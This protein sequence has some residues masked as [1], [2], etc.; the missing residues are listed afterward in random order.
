MNKLMANIFNQLP[1]KRVNKTLLLSRNLQMHVPTNKEGWRHFKDT[2]RPV[3]ILAKL[4]EMTIVP[5]NITTEEE[6]EWK[7]KDS[8]YRRINKNK[9][10][11]IVT[12]RTKENKNKGGKHRAR[13]C[14]TFPAE[15]IFNSSARYIIW[16]PSACT[17]Q[18]WKFRR[19][20]IHVLFTSLCLVDETGKYRRRRDLKCN[21][22]LRNATENRMVGWL[23]G[24]GWNRGDPSPSIPPLYITFLYLN[25]LLFDFRLL[26]F[27]IA[28]SIF[29]HQLLA[30]ISPPH[31]PSLRLLT[32]ALPR[33]SKYY[34]LHFVS[35]RTNIRYKFALIHTMYR[36]SL[37]V[38]WKVS[39]I[40]CVPD[41]RLMVQRSNSDSCSFSAV[42]P[43]NYSPIWHSLKLSTKQ[44]MVVPRH[45]IISSFFWHI[46]SRTSP[47]LFEV[48]VLEYKI[49][50]GISYNINSF[51]SFRHIVLFCP[52]Y[53]TASICV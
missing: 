2:D 36:R 14:T 52:L 9:H 34:W 38:L 23:G 42:T 17:V 15:R 21:G 44:Y 45:F 32:L 27:N 40:L 50:L 25:R 12:E 29:I 20:E 24:G 47:L 46:V 41:Y 19:A 16:H 4:T 10:D 39:F 48:N 8:G 33:L 28:F 18:T 22:S 51:L 5:R 11:R 3:L 13:R 26:H 7:K 49:N 43:N 53:S 6:R 1:N 35:E 37:Y 30:F 31:S